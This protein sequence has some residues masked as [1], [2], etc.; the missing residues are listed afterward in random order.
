MSS[1]SST[2]DASS[3]SGT[4]GASSSTGMGG[5]SSS[6]SSSG[7]T[8]G[9]GGGPIHCGGTSVLTDG[10]SGGDLG[11][12]W[13]I[14]D[15]GGAV[16]SRTGGEAVV[17]L[18]SNSPM[19]SYGEFDSNRAYDF[20]GDSVSI[21]VKSAANPT[22]TAVVWYGTGYEDNYLG[23]YEQHGVL[24]FEQWVAGVKTVLKTTA[25]NPV[26]HRHWRFRE[27][28]LTTYWE[29]SS[30]GVSWTTMTQVATAALFPMDLMW[31]WFGGATEGG[32]VS[33]G[34]IHFDH[35]NGGGPPKGK[36]CPVSSF[37]DN[38]ND[39]VQ[40]LAWSRSWED[41]P[42]MLSETGGKLVVT[43][44][45]NS[46]HSAS[47]VSASAFDL[48]NSSA[49]IE[50]PSAVSTADGSKTR[51][52]LVT[53]GDQGIEISEVQGELHFNI[54]VLNSWQN[55]GS[56]LYSPVQH[57]WWRIRE[58]SNTLYWETSPDGKAWLIQEQLSPVPI[59]IDTLDLHVGSDGWLAQPSPGVSSFDNLNLPPL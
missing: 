39:G 30:D 44:V 11:N 8:G 7:G 59:P 5:A 2:G 45:P 37:K 41:S 12:V 4:G 46:E 49:L 22:T 15:G 21:E 9:E 54:K 35:L 19:S 40:S 25:Y 20:R 32:E 13:S 27:D 42:G 58:S 28:G 26:A 23:I 14:Y 48:T 57:R 43:L 17:V 33:P 6:S 50:V 31:V 34:E 29:T 3:S 52:A 51:I 36:W 18:P 47:Y 16:A 1:S 56:L 10:F 53:P 24:Y 38:F 55:I